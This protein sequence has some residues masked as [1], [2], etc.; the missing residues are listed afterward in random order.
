MTV[1]KRF[2][3]YLLAELI[4]YIFNSANRYVINIIDILPDYKCADLP[5]DSGEQPG[6]FFSTIP[7]YQV[8][9][10]VW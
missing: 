5:D 4:Q 2:K 6:F 3:N 8:A 1:F 7:N 9:E 10:I